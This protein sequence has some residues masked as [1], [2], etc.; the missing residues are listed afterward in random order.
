M[1]T[2]LFHH[3]NMAI[4][5]F[6]HIHGEQLLVLY[7]TFV[8]CFFPS[9]MFTCIMW[10]FMNDINIASYSCLH[11]FWNATFNPYKCRYDARK[12]ELS[13]EHSLYA[14]IYIHF[15]YFYLITLTEFNDIYAWHRRPNQQFWRVWIQSFLSI[16]QRFFFRL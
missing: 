8:Y 2:P 6:I 14:E 5:T 12:K 11:S 16:S 9:L 4:M 13:T 10:L 1:T 15:F 3:L 7:K